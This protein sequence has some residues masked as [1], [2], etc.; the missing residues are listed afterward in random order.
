MT[1]TAPEDPT[2]CYGLGDLF[3][4]VELR[5]HHQAAALCAQCPAT[6]WCESQRIEAV[7]L[8]TS[9]SHHSAVVGTWAGRLYGA[10]VRSED[11]DDYAFER[12][13]RPYSEAEIRQAHAAHGKGDRSVWAV[14][15][16]RLYDRQ[17][18]ARLAAKKQQE[19]AA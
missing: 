6:A 8:A 17:R 16:H 5:H 12:R 13:F 3:E 11:V 14:L 10:G 4:S 1:H 2:P 18:K 15:G 19:D 7:R 9:H